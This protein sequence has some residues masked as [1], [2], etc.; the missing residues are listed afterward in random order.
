MRTAAAY[1]RVSDE[2]QDEFS[3]AS[4]LKRIKEYC[5]NNNIELPEDLIFSDDGISAKST[6]NRKSFN[7]MIALAK[8]KDRPF[9]VIL[10]WK[11][12]R[13]ARN[14]EESIVYKSL[15]KKNGVEV[16]SISEPLAD[17]P[18]GGLIER[19]I[20]WMDE[21]YLIRLADE[22]RRGMTE[23]ATRGLPNVAPPFGYRMVN[24]KYEIHEEEAAIVREIFSLFNEGKSMRY[25]TTYLVNAGIRRKNGKHI[26]NRGVE[27]ILY[28]PCYIG[29]IRYNPNE[30]SASERNFNNPD[31]IVI[32]SNHEPIVSEELFNEVQELLKIR[33]T[34]YHKYAHENAPEE[35]ITMLKGLIRCHSCGSTLIYNPKNNGYQCH[36]YSKGVCGTSHFISQTK[37]NKLVIEEL[38]K[39]YGKQELILDFKKEKH[40]HID[41]DKMISAQK[42][43]LQRIKNAY[44]DGIDTLSEYRVNKQK[45]LDQI[46]QYEEEKASQ[47]KYEAGDVEMQGTVANLIEI[48]NN[49]YVPS[50]AKNK[51]LKIVID[52]VVLIKPGNQIELHYK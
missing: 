33:G 11:F 9:D 17:N 52:K 27:Y 47:A 44:Q 25:I 14:Q 8:L 4:Q 24:G 6:K 50:E 42:L 19:V 13:F 26:D 22:V 34:I 36:K 46:K 28:N 45:V 5:K 35:H 31:D 49:P 51:A 7:E 2:R 37:I 23:R 29:Y 10:V 40:V 3:P 12:S 30:R 15:L 38:D 41:Y 16:I 21:Y 20:E 48:L 1:I 32:K 18:F 39:V 43:K